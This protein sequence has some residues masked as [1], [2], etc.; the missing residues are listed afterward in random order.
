MLGLTFSRYISIMLGRLHMDVKR[1]IEEFK[2]LSPTIEKDPMLLEATPSPG[3]LLPPHN[4]TWPTH[5]KEELY[6]PLMEQHSVENTSAVQSRKDSRRF[7]S[8]PVKCKTYEYPFHISLL[9]YL[10]LDSG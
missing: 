6:K 3:S 4:K 9:S 1:C 2:S 10:F 7:L 8:D 5:K